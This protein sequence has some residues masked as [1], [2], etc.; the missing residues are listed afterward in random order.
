[1][2]KGLEGDRDWYDRGKDAA[3]TLIDRKSKKTLQMSEYGCR[4]TKSQPGFIREV[5]P[6]PEE[7]E[8]FERT[9]GDRPGAFAGHA[10]VE[11]TEPHVRLLDVVDRGVRYSPPPGCIK[12]YNTGMLALSKLEPILVE[13]E[14]LAT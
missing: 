6:T 12:P 7:R 9:R 1:M 14:A 10:V 8:A 13:A 2:P 3:A 11:I 4:I 5:T